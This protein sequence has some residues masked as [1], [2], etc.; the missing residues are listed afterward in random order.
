M[1]V[2]VEFIDH[3]GFWHLKKSPSITAVKRFFALLY[4]GSSITW[5]AKNHCIISQEYCQLTSK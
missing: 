4:P 5:T 1:K 3:K 2:T